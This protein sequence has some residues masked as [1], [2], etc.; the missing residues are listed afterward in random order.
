MPQEKLANCFEGSVAIFDCTSDKNQILRFEEFR[1]LFPTFRAMIETEKEYTV[2]INT[3][4][5]LL[6]MW[7]NTLNDLFSKIKAI[8]EYFDFITGYRKR[9]SIGYGSMPSPTSPQNHLSDIVWPRTSENELN[10]SFSEVTLVTD[11][12]ENPFYF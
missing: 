9:S 4:V 12:G 1:E 8:R 5:G 3:R 2:E 7:E 6:Y 11:F 10:L